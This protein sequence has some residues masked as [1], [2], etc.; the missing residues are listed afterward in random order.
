MAEQKHPLSQAEFDEIYGKVPRLT[1]EVVIRTTDGIVMTEIPSGVAR[2]QWNV[3][4]GTVR[5]AESLP[6]A[7][8]RVAASELGVRVHV[9]ALLGYIEYPKLLRA[10]YRGWPVGLAFECTIVA[11]SVTVNDHGGVVQCFTEVPE[12]TIP[13]Q[14]AF[15]TQYLA[16]HPLLGS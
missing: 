14:A 13:E 4:G 1:V 3:P 2:G 15:L 8:K 6:A 12:N 7:A 11:G 9:G 10:G 16:R 5:F